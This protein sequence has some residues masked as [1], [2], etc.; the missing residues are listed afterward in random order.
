M[1]ITCNTSYKNKND[2]GFVWLDGIFFINIPMVHVHYDD[3]TLE[4]VVMK[5][6]KNKIKKVKK[7]EMFEAYPIQHLFVYIFLSTD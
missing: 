6:K 5:W 7:S 1:K 3:V 4:L 2:V